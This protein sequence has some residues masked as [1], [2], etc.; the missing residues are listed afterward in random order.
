[1]RIYVK[2]VMVGILLKVAL[3]EKVDCSQHNIPFADESF[4]RLQSGENSEEVVNQCC[5]REPHFVTVGYGGDGTQLRV[6][7]G[8]CRQVCDKTPPRPLKR[9][10]FDRYLKKYPNMDPVQIFLALQS[11]IAS[12]NSTSISSPE[13]NHDDVDVDSDEIILPTPTLSRLSSATTSTASCLSDATVCRPTLTRRER[14]FGLGGV[15]HEVEVIET[16]DCVPLSG[17]D[18][19]EKL[20]RPI[21]LHSDTPFETVVDMGECVGRCDQGSGS[22]S[23]CRPVRNKTKSVEGPNG[24]ECMQVIEECACTGGCYRVKEFFKVFD[25][26]H[27]HSLRNSSG[28]SSPA[29]LLDED[30]LIPSL[31]SNSVTTSPPPLSSTRGGGGEPLTKLIDIGRCEGSCFIGKQG[32]VAVTS[33]CLLW[34]SSGSRCLSSLYGGQ[35]SCAPTKLHTHSYTDKKGHNHSLYAVLSCGCQ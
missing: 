33:K 26:S 17:G 20:S 11:R 3:L 22:P 21:R 4:R 35:S 5:K 15:Y 34:S 7:V 28:T 12:T 29:S 30:N 8:T 2:F 19:C 32:Q 23:S 27:I 10:Q 6:D 9:D 13:E 25:Y 14:H 18:G 1:M 31:S 24:V 16:C